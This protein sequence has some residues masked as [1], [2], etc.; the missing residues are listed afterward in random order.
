MTLPAWGEARPISS[1]SEAAGCLARPASW[2][3]GHCPHKAQGD[4]SQLRSLPR[5]QFSGR[6]KRGHTPCRR[7]DG[8]ETRSVIRSPAATSRFAAWQADSTDEKPRPGRRRA[9]DETTRTGWSG[10]FCQLRPTCLLCLHEGE[11]TRPTKEAMPTPPAQHRPRRQPTG[12]WL[13]GLRP[14]LRDSAVGLILQL[15]KANAVVG[16]PEGSGG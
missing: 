7:G 1:L 8:E 14:V 15:Q 3:R 11:A 5:K 4:R 10:P 13:S 12:S 6:S 2:P 9:L 16:R